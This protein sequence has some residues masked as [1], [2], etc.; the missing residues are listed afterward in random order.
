[1]TSRPKDERGFQE[2]C[3]ERLSN[4]KR[5]QGRR[6]DF[7]NY[8]NLHDDIFAE[9]VTCVAGSREAVGLPRCSIAFIMLK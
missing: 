1:M 4:E 7:K 6:D 2:L 3:D 8:P 9:V 5:D